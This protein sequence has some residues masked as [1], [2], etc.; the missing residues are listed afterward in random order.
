[1][2]IY[3]A[4]TTSVT[5][6]SPMKS[7]ETTVATSSRIRTGSISGYKKVNTS[8]NGGRAAVKPVGSLLLGT[9]DPNA[10]FT[11][12]NAS[13]RKLSEPVELCGTK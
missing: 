6:A 1:M 2:P 9:V 12:K 10:D 8:H 13:Q 3:V 11:Q 4:P 5:L 7:G